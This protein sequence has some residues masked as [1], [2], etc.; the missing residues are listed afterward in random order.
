MKTIQIAIT[1]I[2]LLSLTSAITTNDTIKA[3]DV[4]DQVQDVEEDEPDKLWVEVIIALISLIV[5]IFIIRKIQALLNYEVEK[6]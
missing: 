2:L 5:L 6:E 1:T 3:D 4:V